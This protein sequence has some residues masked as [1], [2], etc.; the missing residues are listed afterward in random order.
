MQRNIEIIQTYIRKVFYP[1]EFYTRV[2]YLGLDNLLFSYFLTELNKNA[3]KKRIFDAGNP[4]KLEKLAE[5]ILA[6]SRILK[7][8]PNYTVLIYSGIIERFVR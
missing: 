7:K 5:S 1:K 6:F 3:K 2:H 4:K 8:N